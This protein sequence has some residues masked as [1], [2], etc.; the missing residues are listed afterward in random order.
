MVRIITLLALFGFI[1]GCAATPDFRGVEAVPIAGMTRVKVGDTSVM[2][3]PQ[4]RIS[5]GIVFVMEDGKIYWSKRFMENDEFM[6]LLENPKKVDKWVH[7][8]PVTEHQI[9]KGDVV[10]TC[11]SQQLYC[12]YY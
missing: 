9:K 10:L 1:F 2:I 6:R 4:K 3:V 8:S 11:R 5:N 12:V 7:L